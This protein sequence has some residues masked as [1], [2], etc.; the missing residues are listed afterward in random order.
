MAL[1]LPVPLIPCVSRQIVAS[2]TDCLALSRMSSSTS[3]DSQA[4]VGRHRRVVQN[5]ASCAIFLSHKFHSMTQGDSSIDEYCLCM[6]TVVDALRGVGQPVYEPTLVLNLQP[7]LV[8]NLLCGLNKPYS[9]TTDNI[10]GGANLT[11]A[12]TCN[13][14]L[15]KELRLNNEEKVIVASALVASSVPSCSNS[16]CRSSS[17]CGGPQQHSAPRPAATIRPTATRN[18]I[19]GVALVSAT[20]IVA[21]ASTATQTPTH[22]GACGCAFPHG[23]HSKRDHSTSGGQSSD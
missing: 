23:V 22:Q 1:L 17:S 5:K 4:T 13:Q 16:G 20:S 3:P 8:L 2:T 11:F 9:N 18:P 21:L 19:A 15:L 6:K 14:L 7:T 10:A 12:S